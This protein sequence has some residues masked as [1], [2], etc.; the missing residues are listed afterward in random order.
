MLP[1]SN[2][3]LGTSIHFPDVCKTPMGPMV[4]P[5]PYPDIA[6]NAMAV[7]FSPNIFVG[8]V[9]AT[10][11][12]SMKMM[13]MGDE[14][15]I[16]GG[17]ISGAIKMQG[18][19]LMGN[20]TVL[21]NNIPAEHLLVPTAGN[22]FNAMLGAQVVPSLTSTF[23]M[24][25]PADEHDELDTR[26]ADL[27]LIGRGRRDDNVTAS[28]EGETLV[29]QIRLF[30]ADVPRAVFNLLSDHRGPVVIDLRNNRGG[31]VDV[32]LAVAD[33]FLAGGLVMAR[34]VDSDGDEEIHESVGPA[35]YDAALRLF[36]DGG[37]ASAAELFAAALVDNG[38]ATLHGER[39]Y[40]KATAQALVAAPGGDPA[41]GTVRRFLRADGSSWEGQGL[42]PAPATSGSD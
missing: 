36:I 6:M 38:R 14:V 31:D 16:L 15:G 8:F 7:P 11:M 26:V 3:G 41:Y 22:N 21:W 24:L 25:A 23:V 2:R 30:D 5:M 34:S 32:A 1:A 12:A 19:T 35:C 42:S 20:P 10:N 39:S 9:P 29:L 37:T 28:H 40:G 33:D 27:A 4:L 13:T 18:N 17:L